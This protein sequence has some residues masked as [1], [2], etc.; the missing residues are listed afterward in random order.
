[1]GMS[2]P[3]ASEC[4]MKTTR[5]MDPQSSMLLEVDFKWLMAGHGWWVDTTRLHKDPAYAAACLASA[6]RL[7]SATVRQ[8]A[9]RLQALMARPGVNTRLAPATQAG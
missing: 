7:P 1:M 4:R 5:T 8:C 9:A 6:R 3:S 2:K